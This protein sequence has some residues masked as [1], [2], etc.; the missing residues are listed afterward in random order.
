MSKARMLSALMLVCLLVLG[1]CS[2]A[3][4]E[5]VIIVD[6]ALTERV[7]VPADEPI[8]SGAMSPMLGE[9]YTYTITHADLVDNLTVTLYETEPVP[10]STSYYLIHGQPKTLDANDSFQ[11]TFTVEGKFVVRI[12]FTKNGE[13]V[14]RNLW[15]DSVDRTAQLGQKVAEVVQACIQ[16]GASTDY[17]KALWLHDYLTSHAYYDYT[18]TEYGPDGVLLKGYGVCDSYSKA[19]QMLL[20]EFGIPN[21]RQEGKANGGNHAWNVVY[22][23]GKW[24]QIDQTWDD[25]GHNDV[26]VSGNETH[27]YF[28]LTDSLMG[29]DHDYSIT[30]PC[31]S[32]ANMY[33][34]RNGLPAVYTQF[35]DNGGM[36][37]QPGLFAQAAQG[38]E[39]ISYNVS[40]GYCVYYEESSGGGYSYSMSLY[41][42]Y[43][44]FPVMAYIK[45]RT[46]MA[47]PNGED[48]YYTFTYENETLTGVRSNGPAADGPALNLTYAVGGTPILPGDSVALGQT[49]TVNWEITNPDG[50]P[51]GFSCYLFLETPVTLGEDNTVD[52]SMIQKQG[53]FL[54][55]SEPINGTSASGSFTITPQEGDCLRVQKALKLYADNEY[56]TVETWGED[57]FTLTG[58]QTEPL[59]AEV[60]FSLN[61]EKRT[62]WATITANVDDRIHADWY[63]DEETA[64]KKLGASVLSSGQTGQAWVTQNVE[65]AILLVFTLSDTDRGL[66]CKKVFSVDPTGFAT[67]TADACGMNLTW[68]IQNGTLILS[69]SGAMYD[70][71][72]GRAP[73]YSQCSQITSIQFPVGIT[74]LGEMAFV[75]TAV[76]QVSFPNTLELI[77][78]VAFWNCTSL[79]SVSIPSS[80]R[81]IGYDAFYMCDSLTTFTVDTQNPWYKSENGIIVTKDGTQLVAIPEGAQ[82]L[83]LP[84]GLTTIP[85]MSSFDE[86]HAWEITIPLSVTRIEDDFVWNGSPYGELTDV[87]YLGTRTQF[88]EIERKLPDGS[89]TGMFPVG[90]MINLHLAITPENKR[91]ILPQG[92]QTIE[93][94]AFAGIQAEE[95]VIPFGATTIGA[96]AFSGNSSLIIANIP[97]TVTQIG[98][99]AFSGCHPDLVIMSQRGSAAETYANNNG[100]FFEVFDIR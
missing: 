36:G 90:N 24:C 31:D 1:I 11:H 94:E 64:E 38:L 41:K 83:V 15:V 5:E 56:T 52:A 76:T 91:L 29:V 4:A 87:Y 23:G 19:Y 96:G 93:A 25:P 92:T 49:I 30:Y 63:A 10:D 16:S 53:G 100:I 40:G 86:S 61:A 50:V 75:D 47:G 99:G 6:K 37:T 32:L 74:E 13:S 55:G 78:D 89:V 65:N 51:D 60:V 26:P 39:T 70:Y 2:W 57:V 69:G 3:G 27:N 79:T 73:W 80:V 34:V 97:G 98:E 42:D 17:E 43:I 54:Q 28:G 35:I 22:L 8:I 59:D 7:A 44:I 82:S 84:D 45:S 72:Y 88:A 21:H 62:V 12:T 85:S 20:N 33:Y 9:P 66:S 95:V 48:V 67:L 46:P 71:A 68:T 14:Y 18:Y 58:S 81:E 77:S